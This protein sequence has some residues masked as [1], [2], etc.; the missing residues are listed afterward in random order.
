MDILYHKKTPIQ[1]FFSQ[2]QLSHL[3]NLEQ[4]PGTMKTVMTAQEMRN[5]KS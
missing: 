1:K 2:T 4:D 3:E 5:K